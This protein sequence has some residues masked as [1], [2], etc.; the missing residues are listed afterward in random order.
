[1]RII[2]WTLALAVSAPALAQE[3]GTYAQPRGDEEAASK[4]TKHKDKKKDEAAEAR[5]PKLDV[6]LRA[7]LFAG[8]FSGLGV[9]RATGGIVEAAAAADAETELGAF[10]ISIPLRAGHRQTIGAW[11]PETSG[12]AGIV[13]GARPMAG[14]RVDLRANLL[15]A[16]RP[17]WADLY[18][19]ISTGVYRPTDRF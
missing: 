17:G 18:Q 8:A 15:G 4:E 5:E 16:W 6:D 12:R 19:P 9:R 7:E 1:M 11:L 13:A 14:L 10:R 2:A 3:G